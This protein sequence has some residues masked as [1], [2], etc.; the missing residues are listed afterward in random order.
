MDGHTCL[1]TV[2][3]RQSPKG[4]L[5]ACCDSQTKLRRIKSWLSRDINCRYWAYL[6]T[7]LLDEIWAL[8]CYLPGLHAIFQYVK[9]QQNKPPSTVVEAINI[10]MDTLAKGFMRSDSGC[11][12]PKGL[13]P[14]LP[15]TKGAL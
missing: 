13:A 4:E 5:K 15:H 9:G 6:N 2:Q 14:Q 3:A 11:I 10:D 8:S 7:D 1:Y 12:Q